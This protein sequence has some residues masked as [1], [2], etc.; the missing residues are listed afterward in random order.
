MKAILKV[1]AKFKFIFRNTYTY[2]NAHNIFL[3][4]KKGYNRVYLVDHNFVSTGI[5][6]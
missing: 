4:E 5:H 6:T 3:S 2:K 1:F